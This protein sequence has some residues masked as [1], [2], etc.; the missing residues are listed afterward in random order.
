MVGEPASMIA[1]AVAPAAPGNADEIFAYLDLWFA[2]Q[3]LTVNTD[4]RRLIDLSFDNVI[5]ADDLFAFLDG[6]FANQ[7]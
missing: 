3:G 7:L 1:N 2:N 6:W 5:N 4:Q